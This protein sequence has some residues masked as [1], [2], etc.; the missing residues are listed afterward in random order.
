MTYTPHSL[1]LAHPGRC[2]HWLVP[3]SLLFPLPSVLKMSWLSVPW[4]SAPGSAY[5]T[6]PSPERQGDPE[7]LGEELK[8]PRLSLQGCLRPYLVLRRL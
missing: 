7:C 5:S 4:V 2:P 1:T 6:A 3:Y 8:A